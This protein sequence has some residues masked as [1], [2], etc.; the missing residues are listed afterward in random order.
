MASLRRN[1][2]AEP[3]NWLVP[4][5]VMMLTTDPLFRPYSAG[6]WDCRLNSS[7][8]SIGS[9]EAGAPPMPVWFS[10]ELLKNGREHGAGPPVPGGGHDDRLARRGDPRQLGDGDSGRGR[11]RRGDRRAGR[12][13]GHL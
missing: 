4:D 11:G 10:A 2:N 3:C 12:A 9:K 7:M 1:S 8:A 5:L 13:R 6:N